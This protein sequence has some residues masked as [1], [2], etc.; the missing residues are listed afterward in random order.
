M[1][2]R[3]R[4]DL[5]DLAAL[6]DGSLAPD[7]REA[8]AARVEASPELRGLLDE[9]RR[10]LGVIRAA[11]EPA[12]ASLRAR[13][14]AERDR[15]R[16]TRA[17]SPR[18][19]MI[20]AGAAALALA[21]IAVG[22]AVPGSTSAPSLAQAAAIAARPAIAPAPPAR[23]GAP[24]LLARAESGVSFPNWTPRFGWRTI[25]ARTDTVGGRHA[26]TVFYAYEGHR[27]AYTIVSG[28]ALRVPAGALPARRGSVALASVA[29]GGGVVVT[30]RRRGHTCVLSGP[31]VSRNEL[32]ELASW[33]DA[34]RVQS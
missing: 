27:L 11:R 3:E 29:R 1:S 18:P 24:E 31:G 30:W 16:G 15:A 12:P 4:R 25:G 2:L 19:W 34:G 5:A 22:L 14:A 21:V 28:A 10:A 9:H 17:R 8:V 6:A 32:L 26:T 33:T 7:R 23:A 20:P 13:V